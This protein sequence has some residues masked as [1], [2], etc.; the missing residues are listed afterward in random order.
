MIW[1][2]SRIRILD[3][4]LKDCKAKRALDLLEIRDL[5]EALEERDQVIETYKNV[6][7]PH[8]M[9]LV[10]KAQSFARTYKLLFEGAL[11]IVDARNFLIHPK[12]YD[13][14]NDPEIQSGQYELDIADWSYQSYSYKAFVDYLEAVNREVR[15]DVPRWIREVSDCDNFAGVMASAVQLG[16]IIARKKSQAAFAIAWSGSHAYNLF[17]DTGNRA[18]IYEPQDNRVYGTL[19]SPYKPPSDPDRYSTRKIIFIG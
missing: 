13:P 2:F 10:L 16:C 1:P 18:H 5:K 6:D 12:K 14:W 15:D 7:I 17:W 3:K 4:K 19:T 9:G 11:R 8:Y